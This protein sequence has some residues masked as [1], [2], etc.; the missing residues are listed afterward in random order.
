MILKLQAPGI[1]TSPSGTEIAMRRSER[2]LRR[3]SLERRTNRKSRGE[4]VGEGGTLRVR[5]V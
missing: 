3:Q 2:T 5:L 1:S 4:G